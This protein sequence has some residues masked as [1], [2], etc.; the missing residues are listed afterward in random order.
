VL[1]LY[2]NGDGVMMAIGVARSLVRY[3]PAY[4]LTYLHFVSILIN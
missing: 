1:P 2:F 3:I 4:L